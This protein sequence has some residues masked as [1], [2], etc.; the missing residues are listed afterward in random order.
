MVRMASV[1]RVRKQRFT[2]IDLRNRS[3]N[4]VGIVVMMHMARV[5]VFML[6]QRC[7]LVWASFAVSSR[8]KEVYA[9]VQ[10]SQQNQERHCKRGDAA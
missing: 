4:R 6:E 9:L 2:C 10:G 3:V 1:R 5:A 7:G 8:F